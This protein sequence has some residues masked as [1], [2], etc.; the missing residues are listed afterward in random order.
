MPLRR[1]MVPE[2]RRRSSTRSG[3]SAGSN[4]GVIQPDTR[5]GRRLQGRGI[6]DRDP[7]PFCFPTHDKQTR[8]E[9]IVHT[10]PHAPSVP[11]PFRPPDPE[12]TL[13]PLTELDDEIERLGVP[14]PCRTFDPE[15]FF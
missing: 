2:S 6:P 1:P 11:P 4:P 9:A 8:N 3:P 10:P 13:I 15:V 5:S 14:V 12:V 7:R